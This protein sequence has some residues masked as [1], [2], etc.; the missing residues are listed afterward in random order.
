MYI[1]DINEL[2]KESILAIRPYNTINFSQFMRR[3][4]P[5]IEPI[6]LSSP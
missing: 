6:N 4:K 3:V 1:Y 5:Q 2:G